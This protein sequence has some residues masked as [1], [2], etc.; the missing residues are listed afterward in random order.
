MA[1]GKHLQ[2]ELLLL[3]P[4]ERGGLPGKK[5]HCPANILSQVPQNERAE[6]RNLRPAKENRELD[7]REPGS[8]GAE[9]AAHQGH[10]E[11]Q[12]RQEP[13]AG[14]DG[15]APQRHERAQEPPENVPGGREKHSQG[16]GKS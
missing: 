9:P 15:R 16:A 12:Q 11:V 7:L 14:A 8:E 3:T 6:E 2:P 5:R 4:A 1:G 10:G 13:P